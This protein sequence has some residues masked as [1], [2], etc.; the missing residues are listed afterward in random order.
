MSNLGFMGK[1]GGGRGFCGLEDVRRSRDS[2]VT[3]LEGWGLRLR[4]V[5]FR[6]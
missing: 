1:D 4:V 3:G 6:V 2:I 5:G